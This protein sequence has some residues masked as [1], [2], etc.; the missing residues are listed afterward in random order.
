[1]REKGRYGEMKREME[2]ESERR[3]GKLKEKGVQG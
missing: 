3:R 2:R 1:M